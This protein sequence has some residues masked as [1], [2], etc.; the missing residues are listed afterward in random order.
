MNIKRR[1][2]RNFIFWLFLGLAAGFFLA[3][4]LSYHEYKTVAEIADSVL[5]AERIMWDSRED[6]D[7]SE[8][9]SG[10]GKNVPLSDALAR[11]LKE[12]ANGKSAEFVGEG[13]AFLKLHGYY[14]MRNWR[15]YLPFTVGICA[16]LFQ[17]AGWV[18]F[19]VRR[20][21]EIRIK[22]RIRELTG[23][24][25]AVNQ[26]EGA[27]LCR[28]EDI[29]SH[30]EDEIYKTVMELRSTKEVAVR[31]HE[32]LAERIADIA[33]QLKT[34]L[35]SMSLMTELLEEY[36]TSE[37]REYYSRLSNQIERLRILVSGLLSLAKL[38][39]HGIVFQKER[40]EI[41]ELIENAA[42]PLREMMEKRE[43]ML[44]VK[45]QSSE[46]MYD[47]R[48][49]QGRRIAAE[50]TGQ[51]AVIT[52][53]QTGRTGQEAGQR[54]QN[55]GC[56]IYA[57]RQWT[58]EALLNILKNCVEHTP[59]G[60]SITVLYSQNPIYTELWIE[61]GGSGFQAADLPHIFERFYRGE[62]AAKDNVGIG[63][64]LAKAVLEQQNGQITAGNT[65]EGHAFFGLKWY[66][67]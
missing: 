33:H 17:L 3:A 6:I 19:G 13:E 20:R 11:C 42:E 41:S 48:T 43:V 56:R 30:L 62:S 15:E 60:G 2:V 36:Q 64:A 5:A 31:N 52:T 26:G 10:E 54:D 24:L 47:G 28:S 55:T 61:D 49:G 34:P 7:I 23:Y 44:L 16:F 32:V 59:P 57:D 53:G 25:R 8:E 40:L 51:D 29:F 63:L 22:G 50:Q 35:T 37:T 45:E 39:S 65:A 38:D 27:A 12:N 66:A 46:G 1:A 4:V 18:V 9:D 67:G 21:D 58:E 14:P